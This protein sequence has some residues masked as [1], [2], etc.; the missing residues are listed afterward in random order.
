MST[1]PER[2]PEIA[3]QRANVGS[4]RAVDFNVE[5]DNAVGAPARSQHL[6]PVDAHRSGFEFDVVALADQL[7]CTTPTDLDRADR[8]R[9]LL[10]VAAQPCDRGGDLL[11][12]QVLS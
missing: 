1:Y 3:G 7:I 8:R 5:I 6:E 10:D 11:L 9:H 2:V 4:R 12:C